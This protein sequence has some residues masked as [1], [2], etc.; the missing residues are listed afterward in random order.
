[1]KYILFTKHIYYTISL[2]SL[3][4]CTCLHGLPTSHVVRVVEVRHP[5]LGSVA[6]AHI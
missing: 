2:A 5:G 4:L 3:S 1:M 6:H